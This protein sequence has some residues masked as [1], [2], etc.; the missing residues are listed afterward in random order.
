MD[1]SEKQIHVTCFITNPFEIPSE[2]RKQYAMHVN[3][4]QKKLF[5]VVKTSSPQHSLCLYGS[6]ALIGID[7]HPQMAEKMAPP[8]MARLDLDNCICG[9]YNVFDVFE[10]MMI[11]TLM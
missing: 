8:C 11:T 10:V 6:G 7:F 4:G 5:L 9:D 3:E 2:Q 1:L